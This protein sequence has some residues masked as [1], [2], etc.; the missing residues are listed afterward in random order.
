MRRIA[1]VCLALMLLTGCSTRIR[2]VFQP[3]L[4][5]LWGKTVT[6]SKVQIPEEAFVDPES[7]C[8]TM[9]PD[10]QFLITDHTAPYLWDPETK[11]KTYLTP[12]G[13]E[14]EELLRKYGVAADA[15]EAEIA[16]LDELHGKDL[17]EYYLSQRNG[18]PQGPPGIAVSYYAEGNCFWVGDPM[19]GSWMI[20]ADTG[21]MYGGVGKQY[22]SEKE[23]AWMVLG[24]MPRMEVTLIDKKTGQETRKSYA[25]QAGFEKEGCS[26]TAASFLPDGSICVVLRDIMFDKETGEV[27]KMVIERP[28]G[29]I[30]C[31]DLGRI[32]FGREPDMILCADAEH[33]L[34]YASR[35]AFAVAPYMI[36]TKTGDVNVL[37]MSGGTM[38]TDPA[39]DHLDKNGMMPKDERLGEEQFLF[40]ERLSDGQTLLIQFN[41]GFPA[42]FRPDTLE[43]S[44]IYPDGNT[45]T[46]PVFFS[47]SGNHYDRL[48]GHGPDP[49]LKSYWQFNVSE[50]K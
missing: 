4:P 42:L 37:Y 1:A 36:D 17:L 19:G 11:E 30:E 26:I 21:K 44:F 46:I 20:D 34:L 31:Y 16:K 13:A 15:T 39:K 43:I 18:F 9:A 10:G 6:Y 47:F 25:A 22:V 28:D 32:S 45:D 24:M 12:A 41:G 7:I 14:E 27:C 38:T 23:D 5:T 35:Y 3:E 50:T 48:V 49:D 8:R 40:V 29:S 33:I 2:D